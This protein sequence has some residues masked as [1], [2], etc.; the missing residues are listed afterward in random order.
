MVRRINILNTKLCL[1]NLHN[2][3]KLILKNFVMEYTDERKT[4]ENF[5]QVTEAIKLLTDLV[6][7]ITEDGLEINTEQLLKIATSQQPLKSLYVEE[8][9][10]RTRKSPSYVQNEEVARATERAGLWQNE[11]NKICRCLILARFKTECF[12]INQRRQVRFIGNLKE[13]C[14]K[15]NTR[16]AN[17]KQ[18]KLIQS[19]KAFQKTLKEF[20]KELDEAGQTP[21][22][23]RIPFVF[24]KTGE[25][26][27]PA[28]LDVHHEYIAQKKLGVTKSQKKDQEKR[29]AQLE[30]LES[31][32]PKDY[33]NREEEILRFHNMD[34]TGD[35]YGEE[36]FKKMF[37]KH[38]DAKRIE[39]GP[40][41]QISIGR[42]VV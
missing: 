34:I 15:I 3:E 2:N 1:I 19:I 32:C 37:K 18:L 39:G 24:I 13:A 22:N 42:G 8:A 17:A 16:T 6:G 14:E 10:S 9:K 36:F 12:T 29:D 41:R 38:K 11:V 30:R 20:D 7:K 5:Q 40:N 35:K 4:L 26:N 31:W 33:P 27:L 21:M 25:I 23:I 28:I